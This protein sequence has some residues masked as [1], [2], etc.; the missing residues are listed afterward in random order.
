MDLGG[1]W[2]ETG[3]CGI[4]RVIGSSLFAKQHFKAGTAVG[5]TA[6]RNKT[7]AQ[8]QSDK[9]LFAKKLDMDGW[10]EYIPVHGILGP[11]CP[12]DIGCGNEN[13]TIGTHNRRQKIHIIFH[14]VK[15]LDYFR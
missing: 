14:I 10:R 13:H 4:S 2:E 5:N 11:A 8:K 15:M 12:L 7:I 1:N 3:G 6:Q 9:G